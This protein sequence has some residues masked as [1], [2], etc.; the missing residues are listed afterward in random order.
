MAYRAIA[1][2]LGIHNTT[3]MR[4]LNEPAQAAPK[5]PEEMDAAIRRHLKTA[6]MHPTE[7][8]AELGVGIAATRKLL[9]DMERRAYAGR[10]S[11]RPL[12]DDLRSQLAAGP[13]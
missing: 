5:T 6:P 13:V 3:V 1:A 11:Q 7:L 2:Q 9:A 10:A 8:A 4:Y 12:A